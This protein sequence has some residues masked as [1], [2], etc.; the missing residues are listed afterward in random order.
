MTF[1]WP[2][3]VPFC[4]IPTYSESKVKNFKEEQTQTGHMD[5]VYTGSRMLS[6]Y[7]NLTTPAMTNTQLETFWTWYND[8]LLNGAYGFNVERL[9]PAANGDPVMVSYKFINEHPVEDRVGPGRYKLKFSIQ[10]V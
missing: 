6:K 2:S 1:D 5:R 4:Q 7:S 9:R 8:T 10:E 3:T